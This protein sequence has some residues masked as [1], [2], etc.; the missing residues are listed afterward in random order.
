MGSSLAR[1]SGGFCDACKM[2]LYRYASNQETDGTQLYRAAGLT[3]T[4]V[5]TKR[6]NVN[7]DFFLSMTVTVNSHIC[8]ELD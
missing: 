7:R 8:K 4:L 6:L 2:Q 5:K 3:V 1:R